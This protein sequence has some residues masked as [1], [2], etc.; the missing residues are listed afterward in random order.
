MRNLDGNEC[1]GNTQAMHK[2]LFTSDA[3]VQYVWLCG[4]LKFTDVSEVLIALMLEAASTSKTS[5]N[6]YQSTWSNIPEDSHLHTH[7]CENLKFQQCGTLLF[8]F[9]LTFYK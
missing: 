6:F 8:L 2:N 9:I 3:H 7:R 4:T 5:V 1:K